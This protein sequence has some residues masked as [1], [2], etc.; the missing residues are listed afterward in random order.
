M[1]RIPKLK[2]ILTSQ[3]LNEVNEFRVCILKSESSFERKYYELKIEDIFD[4]AK[5]RYHESKKG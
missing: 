5:L 2:D 1:G 3:E 4:N